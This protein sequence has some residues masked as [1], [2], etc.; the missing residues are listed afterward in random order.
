[1][2][3]CTQAGSAH[4][5]EAMKHGKAT[6][7]ALALSI[8]LLAVGCAQK[9]CLQDY[10]EIFKRAGLPPDL[11]C[12]P[13][14]ACQNTRPPDGPP[15]DVDNPE[16]QPWFVTLHECLAMA[17]ENGTT[18]LQSVRLFGTL[19]DDLVTARQLGGNFFFGDSIRVLAYDPAILGTNIEASLAR[20]DVVAR[21]VLGF[22]TKDFV[23][24]S[25]GFFQNGQFTSAGVKL[26]KANPYGGL[27]GITF[28][29]DPANGIFGAPT[30]F[31]GNLARPNLV[32]GTLNP[33]YAPD[34]RF[35]YSQ[36][37][38]KNWGPDINSLLPQH[39]E[40]GQGGAQGL[41][42]NPGSQVGIV[43]T[44]IAFDQA[45]TDFERA[46]TFMLTNIEFAYWNLYGS[47]VNLYATE[48]GMRM[49]H[50]TWKVGK[51]QFDAGKIGIQDVSQALGQFEQFRGDRLA[52]LGKVLEAERT[53]RGLIGLPMDDGKRLVPVDK[54]TVSPY[55]PDWN[56]ALQ[57][58]K[59]L[60]PELIMQRLDLKQKQ[61]ELIREKNTLLPELALQARYSIHGAGTRLD[62][63]SVGADGLSE[64]AF[65][66]LASDHFNDYDIG[67]TFA[68]PLGFRAQY[69]AV[70]AA[71][72]RLAQSYFQLS[73]QEY[74]AERFLTFAYRDVI[75]KFKSIEM[76]RSQ[77]EAYTDQLEARFKL[78]FAGSKVPDSF[79][80][81]AQRDWATALQQEYQAVVDYNNALARFHFAKGTALRYNS[82]TIGEGQL[83][84]CALSPAVEHERKRADAI[85]CRERANVVCNPPCDNGAPRPPLPEL[86]KVGPPSLP[87]LIQS[88]PP[89]PVKLDD[90][91]PPL[92]LTPPKTAAPSNISAAPATAPTPSFGS[93]P[94][95]VPVTMPT[96]PGPLPAPTMQPAVP[97]TGVSWSGG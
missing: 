1:M 87:A 44:R 10:D 48:Q 9:C 89:T 53:L 95:A 81:Q 84:V 77:R 62:G 91:L 39:P 8:A 34:L 5:G 73:D 93:P 78:V 43:I 32:T 86:P 94:H 11:E 33:Q 52:A 69:A 97:V 82:I 21:S 65:R 2:D 29:S 38:L 13:E 19:D 47:F 23:T 27:A 56:S 59:A 70:R 12:N 96:T 18:G 54:P 83:P 17:L 37:L 41:S 72:L 64:N 75:E 80:L 40:I 90:V 25:N 68:M 76:R 58:C 74:R 15:S 14:K 67:L 3:G 42:T 16:R 7:F 24:N 51:A 63:D 66:S 20:Y 30:P 35:T 71:K 26:E 57:E 49:A 55:L 79:L 45:R 22:S 28:G 46:V 60:R 88:S 36:P 61:M 92:A 85:V 50:T 4:A 6:V 31:Y